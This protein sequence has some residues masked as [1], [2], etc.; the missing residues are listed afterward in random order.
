MCKFAMFWILYKQIQK[1]VRRVSN[2]TMTD[3]LKSIHITKTLMVVL[4][5][6]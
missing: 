3:I 1:D 2:D 5:G 6:K 4:A